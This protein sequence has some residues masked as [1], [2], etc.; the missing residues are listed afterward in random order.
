MARRAILLAVLLCAAC[1]LPA[2]WAQEETDEEA[3]SG[4]CC[5]LPP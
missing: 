1:A 4:T 2:A 3:V 5:V